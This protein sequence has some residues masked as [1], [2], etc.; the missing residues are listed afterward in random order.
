MRGTTGIKLLDDKYAEV[1]VSNLPALVA[2]EVYSL[3]QKGSTGS[4]IACRVWLYLLD[5]KGY[6]RNRRKLGS[7]EL[8][9]IADGEVL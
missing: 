4:A 8:F 9:T 7:S 5:P 6:R 1:H 3:H 2:W